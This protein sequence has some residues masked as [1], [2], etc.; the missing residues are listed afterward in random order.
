MCGRR[1]SAVPTNFDAVKKIVSDEVVKAVVAGGGA[2]GD[3]E[4]AAKTISSAQS[5]QQLAGVI[6]NYKHLMS[7]QLSGLKKQYET[8]TMRNDFNQFL[9]P[10]TIT[11][12]EK[13]PQTAGGDGWSIKLKGQ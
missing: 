12:L 10:D 4:E 6:A 1:R 13:P 2:L 9:L 7:G 3:R 8:S 11:Q 5:P